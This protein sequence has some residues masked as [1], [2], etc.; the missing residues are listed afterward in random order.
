MCQQNKHV[1]ISIIQEGINNSVIFTCVLGKGDWGGKCLNYAV[2][3]NN[4]NN[5]KVFLNEYNTS[6]NEFAWDPG[7]KY[8]NKLVS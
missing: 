8:K 7:P 6:L 4:N 3:S 5:N 1:S 2:F